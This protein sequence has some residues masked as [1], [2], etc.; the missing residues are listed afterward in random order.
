MPAAAAAA[1][2]LGG[3]AAIAASSERSYEARA[4]VL[5]RQ[6]DPAVGVDEQPP[7]DSVPKQLV[8]D[9]A[10]GDLDGWTAAE[11]NDAS[12]LAPEEP[13]GLRSVTVRGPEPEQVAGAADALAE[14]FVLVWNAEAEER[15]LEAIAGL[16][17]RL[18]QAGP[19]APPTQRRELRSQLTEQR[20]LA[21]LDA[22]GA[23]LAAG[24]TVTDDPTSPDLI[25]DLVL[26]AG[27]TLAL[28]LTA[29]LL[30]YASASSAQPGPQ[31]RSPRPLESR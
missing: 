11:L 15:R 23:E 7:V 9:A 17:R 8:L 10:L 2:L 5:A 24:A 4:L 29:T 13:W 18:R 27:A 26:T 20:L 12:V 28:A 30:V 25:R 6:L 16:R 31:G 14:A 1:L 21:L 22:G 19:E 3:V